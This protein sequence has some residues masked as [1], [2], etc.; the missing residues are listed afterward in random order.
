MIDYWPIRPQIQPDELLTSW[1]KRISNRYTNSIAD[2]MDVKT[3]HGIHYDYIDLDPNEDLLNHLSKN[4]LIPIQ[5]LMHHSFQLF[6]DHFPSLNSNFNDVNRVLKYPL[7]KPPFLLKLYSNSSKNSNVRYCPLCLSEEIPYFRIYWRFGYYTACVKHKILMQNT[8]PICSKPI[9]FFNTKS[10]IH[11]CQSC[12]ADLRLAPQIPTQVDAIKVFHEAFWEKISPCKN[13]SSQVFLHYYWKTFIQIINRYDNYVNKILAKYGY[14]YET[15]NSLILNHNIMSLVWDL[16][17]EE[18]AEPEKLL[19]CLECNSTFKKSSEL[20]AHI[21]YKHLIPSYKCKHCG[22]LYPSK[23][24]LKIHQ[25]EHKNGT[26]QCNLCQSYFTTKSR[27]SKHMIRAHKE[28]LI[29]KINNIMK[30]MSIQGKRITYANLSKIG[31][32]STTVF[33]KHTDI[34]DM[35]K[36]FIRK[37]MSKIQMEYFDTKD[38]PD[39]LKISSRKKLIQKAIQNLIQDGIAPTQRTVS[40]KLGVS[41]RLFSTNYTFNSILKQGQIEYERYSQQKLLT[42]TL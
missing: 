17:K 29:K 7:T 13:L 1:I 6:K 26:H 31:G 40:R 37:S 4:T 25:N 3:L 32:F 34:H 10:H 41:T 12:H 35:I 16:F 38:L 11:E 21:E 23:S 5:N 9:Q 8:C 19:P 30:D 39:S 2:I 42:S 20:D 14:R 36:D 27:L 18:D 15:D 33:E 22:E 28:Q 24:S